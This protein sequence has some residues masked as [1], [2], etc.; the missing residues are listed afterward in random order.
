MRLHLKYL[1]GIFPFQKYSRKSL[2]T[3]KTIVREA[4]ISDK[5]SIANYLKEQK[6]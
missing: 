4:Q 3:I 2:L 1:I 5:N 6:S